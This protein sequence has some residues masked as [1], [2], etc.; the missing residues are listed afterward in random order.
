MASAPNSAKN[1]REDKDRR[2]F[3]RYSFATTSEDSDDASP[4]DE[5]YERSGRRDSEGASSGG[6]GRS[7]C[8]KQRN[9]HHRNSSQSLTS[10]SQR[11]SV[12]WSFAQK[13]CTSRVKQSAQKGWNRSA[14]KI[15]SSAKSVSGDPGRKS[16]LHNSNVASSSS[17]SASPSESPSRGSVGADQNRSTQGA[18]SLPPALKQSTPKKDQYRSQRSM[19]LGSANHESLMAAVASSSSRGTIHTID[20][21]RSENG[22]K[23]ALLVENTRFVV[24]PNV[25]TAKPDTMLGRMFSVRSQG[26]E[27]AE[28]VRPNEHN[29]YEVAEGLSAPCFQA[30][31]EYYHTGKMSCPPSVSASELR[32]ACDYL[33]VPF[34]AQ[35]VRCQNLRSFLH[36]LSNEGAKQQFTEFLEEIILPQMVASTEHGDRECHIVVLLDDDVVDWDEHYPPQMG[37][38]T[39]QVVYSTQLYRFF[40]YA[41]NRD[42]AKQVL[43]E[44]GLKKIRLGMEGYPT[45]KEKIKRRFNK[46]EVIYNYVQRPFVHCSWEK[47]EARSRHVDFACPIVKS[48]SNPSLAS[49]ASDPLPQPAPLQIN[50]AVDGIRGYGGGGAANNIQHM[51]LGVGGAPVGNQYGQHPLHS[52]PIH[53]GNGSAHG[54]SG[55]DGHGVGNQNGSDS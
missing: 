54:S 12:S 19:S 33:L 31:L 41:E 6:S 42:V 55:A 3:R 51:L 11:V 1:F 9:A 7:S 47:E 32:E 44:R 22:E 49:A 38:D 24:D 17:S 36:E 25:L 28:L 8:L 13:S 4:V 21:S 35:T 34:N 20:I 48:K 26:H 52:P 16:C 40:K 23:V 43:K 14:S 39:T 37:E 53:F 15:P 18:P 50:L 2:V 46:A 5:V 29:E 10:G 45:H 30:I 27:G